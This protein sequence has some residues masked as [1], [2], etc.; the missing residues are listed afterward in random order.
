MRFWWR[1]KTFIQKHPNIKYLLF[2]V[3]G[4]LFWRGTWDLLDA[5]LFPTDKTLSA[6][7]SV[8]A[9]LVLVLVL[10]KMKL[11]DLG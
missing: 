6:L 10:N 7:V 11:R 2:G 1:H 9:G 4:V 5:Y 8:G 3:A